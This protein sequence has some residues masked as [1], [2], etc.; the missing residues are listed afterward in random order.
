M[1]STG[2]LERPLGSIMGQKAAGAGLFDLDMPC[3]D[4]AEDTVQL[5]FLSTFCICNFLEVETG[6]ID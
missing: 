4:G 2:A 3:H 6:Q 1:A 5:C